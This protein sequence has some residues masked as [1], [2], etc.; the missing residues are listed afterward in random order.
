MTD[1]EA[2][3][4]V[5]LGARLSAATHLTDAASRARAMLDLQAEITE[6]LTAV[7][8]EAI[9]DAVHEIGRD[10]TAEKIGRSPGE[11]GRRITAHNRRVGQ[12]GR[13]GRRPRQPN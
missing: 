4:L 7:I 13:P 8:N 2:A 9:A 5:D 10:R 6:A 3:R 1:P 11:V 12:P